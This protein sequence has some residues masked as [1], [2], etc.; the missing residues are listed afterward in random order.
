MMMKPD[1]TLDE[2]IEIMNTPIS[3]VDAVYR[4]ASDAFKIWDACLCAYQLG[5]EVGRAQWRE[6]KQGNPNLG[7]SDPI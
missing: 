5:V 6:Q 3:D 1:M 2:L 4:V 7:L